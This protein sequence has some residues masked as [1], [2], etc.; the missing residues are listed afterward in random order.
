MLFLLLHIS[1]SVTVHHIQHLL[2]DNKS[3]DIL[4]KLLQGSK[5]HAFLQ[6]MHLFCCVCQEVLMHSVNWTQAC[7]QFLFKVN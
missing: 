6:N 4:F 5:Q 1:L 7:F 3:Q 2:K